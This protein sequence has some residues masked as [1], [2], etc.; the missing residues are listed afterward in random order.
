MGIFL[1]AFKRGRAAIVAGDYDERDVQADIIKEK[2][3]WVIG[4]RAI[5][6]LQ[7]GKFWDITPAILDEISE[8][9][10]SKFDFTVA[11]AAK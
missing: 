10:A 9:I 4:I 3:S 7:Q 5:Y 11:E 2:I 8:E 6:Y 1:D